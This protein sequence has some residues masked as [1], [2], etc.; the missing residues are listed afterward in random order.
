MKCDDMYLYGE[1]YLILPQPP[2]NFVYFHFGVYFI[3]GRTY[4]VYAIFGCFVFTWD[5]LLDVQSSHID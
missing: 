1:V 3:A 5:K 4:N 2:Q